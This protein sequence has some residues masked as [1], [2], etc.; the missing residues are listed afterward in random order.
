MLRDAYDLVVDKY[1][2]E[3]AD[4]LFVDNPRAAF[5]GETL[6]P[7]PEPEGL[8]PELDPKQSSGILSKMFG[9]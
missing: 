6:P 7:Q 5:F 1:G 4:R 3:T 9:W 2:K 8:H